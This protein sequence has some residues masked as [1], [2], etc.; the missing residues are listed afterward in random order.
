MNVEVSVVGLGKLGA[1]MA[2]AIAS[3]SV[4]TTGVD[5]NSSP[6]EAMRE[7]RAP[8]FEPGLAEMIAGCDGLLG[9]T[10]DLEAAIRNSEITFVV[11]PTPSN[12]EG[13]FSLEYVS[14]AMR[15][16]GRALQAKPEYHLVVLT[17]T[18]L[19][20]S[21]EY[22]IR[23]LLEETSGK[24]CGPDFGLCYSPEFIALGSVLRDFLN[25]DF[26]LVGECDAKAGSRLAAFYRDS[27]RL[28][29]PVARMSA[30]NAELA[31][32]AL[33]TYVTSKITFA[34]MLAEIC[35]RLPG[36]DVDAVTGAL[37]L[38]QRIG[39][40][41]LKGALGYGGPCFPR[42]NQALAR[43]M[44]QIGLSSDLPRTVDQVNHRQA[45]RVV[46]LV[47][48][49]SSGKAQRVSVLGLAYKPDTN[50][51]EQS[52]GIAIACQLVREGYDVAVFDPAATEN[53]RRALGDSVHYASNI[54]DCVRGATVI[55]LAT[56]WPEFR[57][58]FHQTANN[59]P[60]PAIVDGWR[61]LRGSSGFD[62]IGYHP[63]GL[64]G[65][66][67]E[68]RERLRHFAESLAAPRSSKVRKHAVASS[69]GS[70]R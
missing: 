30:I 46:G 34:N 20:G 35:E 70:P 13:A 12:K 14:E 22:L 15:A 65:S 49:L 59:V 21:T 68:T 18:V 47:N 51:V 6:V 4:R 62:D 26:L 45:G 66:N 57:S 1:C 19:P 53:A 40:K 36:G 10:Q 52:Q 7:K 5:V 2:A 41:Y 37:G 31:K 3:R 25:P 50:V 11:V 54:A 16:V 44:E 17:S 24:T 69:V 48:R 32:I 61:M 39:S 64:G 56:D 9:A 63:V 43:F 42:D 23:P 8:I 29:A 27:L 55:V 28:T 67:L 58:L 33:N 38:D 60:R